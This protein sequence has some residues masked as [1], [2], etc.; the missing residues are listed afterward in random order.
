M[1]FARHRAQD[2]QEARTSQAQGDQMGLRKSMHDTIAK[3]GAWVKQM[4][5][6]FV[7]SGN[8][9]SLFNEVRWLWLKVAQ[10]AQ[11]ELESL[12]GKGL[13]D[14]FFPPIRV[15]HPMPFTASTSKP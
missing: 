12:L 8:D 15:L 4:L 7:V 9:P 5:N 3:T 11:P 1:G 14:R 2:D 10:A 13:A 6:Y